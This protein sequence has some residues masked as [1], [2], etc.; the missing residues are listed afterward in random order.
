MMPTN[1]KVQLT[2]ANLEVAKS[3][4]DLVSNNTLL[5]WTRFQPLRG[6][7]ITRFSKEVKI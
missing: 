5:D 3:V 1:K 2:G 4:N 6:G 7:W